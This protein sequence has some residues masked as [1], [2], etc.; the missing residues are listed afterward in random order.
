MP[1]GAGGSANEHYSTLTFHIDLPAVGT[2][3]TTVFN[4]ALGYRYRLVS[5][6]PK[7]VVAGTGAGATRAFTVVRFR[8]GVGTAVAAFTPTLA[9]TA[10][11]GTIP[12]TL[13]AGL[14]D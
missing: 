1:V 9:N 12:F 6:I 7:A 13:T 2:S 4:G 3:A 8:G 5:G 11:A 10:F 14:A